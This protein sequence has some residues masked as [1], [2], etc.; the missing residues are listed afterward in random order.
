M[1]STPNAD[2]KALAGG[3]SLLPMLNMR[4]AAPTMLVDLGSIPELQVLEKRGD[5]LVVGA[6]VRQ[7]KVEIAPLVRDVCPLLPDMLR[8]VGHVQVRNRGT[9][10]GSI[11]HADPVAELALAGLVMDAAVTLAGPDGRRILSL[12]DLLVGPYMTAIRDDELLVDIRFPVTPGRHASH[13]VSRRHGDFAVAGVVAFRTASLK[14]ELRLGV[15]GLGGTPVRLV[16]AERLAASEPDDVGA[17]VACVVDELSELGSGWPDI[18]YRR[19]VAGALAR[20]A[21]H[22]VTR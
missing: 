4:I 5:E 9:I 22:E 18:E 21:I 1:L 16:D 19:R 2:V 6:M 10:G 15:M 11:A 3:Q 13:E 17:I 7:R 12:G 8:Y 14:P 20:R